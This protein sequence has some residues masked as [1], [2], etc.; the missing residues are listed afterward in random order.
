MQYPDKSSCYVAADVIRSLNPNAGREVE[1][2]LGC[3][4]GR[5]CAIDNAVVF[6]LM[7]RYAPSAML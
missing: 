3:A 7:D 6:D 2:A 1:T 4:D 5:E